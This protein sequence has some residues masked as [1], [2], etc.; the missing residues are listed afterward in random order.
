MFIADLLKYENEIKS[1][2]NNLVLE[3]INPIF[4][5]LKGTAGLLG[6]VV[7]ST[8][9]LECEQSSAMLTGK[10]ISTEPIASLLKHME[11][12]RWV[13]ETTFNAEVKSKQND[14]IVSSDQIDL[15]L[16]QEL[17]QQLESSNMQ[18]VEVFKALYR[19]ISEYSNDLAAILESHINELQFKEALDL[20]GK[21]ELQLLEHL[22]G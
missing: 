20:V 12:I 14:V 6:F 18:A 4:H 8:L 3:T 11:S 13:L 5:T 7:L 21:L 2:N 19:P 22:N 15:V 10:N 9:A 16:L 1:L 17:K